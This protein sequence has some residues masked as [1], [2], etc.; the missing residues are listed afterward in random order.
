MHQDCLNRTNAPLIE[1]LR[2]K[3][4]IGA[5]PRFPMKRIYAADDGRCWELNDIR[6]Q[7]WA[8]HWVRIYPFLPNIKL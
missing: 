2:L 7:V 5:D 4:P 1:Q 8:F 6:L 3:Y